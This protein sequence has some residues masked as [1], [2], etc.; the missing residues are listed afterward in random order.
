MEKNIERIMEHLHIPIVTHMKAASARSTSTS[1]TEETPS[2]SKPD[3]VKGS[4][5]VLEVCRISS[6]VISVLNLIYSV[7]VAHFF[8]CFEL[9]PSPL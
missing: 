6:P 9:T 7:I 4:A 5:A 1:E 2:L 3:D 8:N